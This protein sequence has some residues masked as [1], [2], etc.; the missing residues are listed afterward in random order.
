MGHAMGPLRTADMMG[1]DVVLSMLRSMHEQ[2]GHPR[3]AA[4]RR[5]V[6]LVE[7]GKLGRKTGEGFYRY[8]DEA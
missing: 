5:L 2:T 4:P 3:Y 1:L 6:E 8:P 7:A